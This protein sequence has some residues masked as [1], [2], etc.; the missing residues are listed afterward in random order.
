MGKWLDRALIVG[1]FLMLCLSDADFRA[2]L[3]RL[4]IDG[5]GVLF[6]R[7]DQGRCNWFV[8]EG[9]HYAFVCIDTTSSPPP[10]AVAGLLVHEAVHVFQ[11]HCEQIGEEQPS[12]EFEAWSIQWIAQQLMWSFEEQT[13]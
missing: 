12:S 3:K 8:S 10:I 6:A 11:G 2:A 5:Q 4:K 9:K 7:K 1:P 13:R